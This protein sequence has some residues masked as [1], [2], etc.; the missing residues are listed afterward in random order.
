MQCVICR[1]VENGTEPSPN[2]RDDAMIIMVTREDIARNKPD[3]Y[4]V[5]AH[6]STVGHTAV[7]GPHTR[8]HEL[9]VS[10]ANVL[11]PPGQGAAV[12]EATFTGSAAIVGSMAVGVMRRSFDLALAFAK[13]E[14]RGG[15]VPILQRQSVADLLINVKMRCESSRSLVWRAAYALEQKGNPELAYETKIFCSD[16]AVQSVVDAMNAVGVSVSDSFSFPLVL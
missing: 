11:C 10:A 13:R 15:S 9:R 14:A 8:F 12:V 7:S 1:R 4:A 6:P 3:A 2:P 16:N 5:L